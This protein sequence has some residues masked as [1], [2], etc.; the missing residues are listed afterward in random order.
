MLPYVLGIDLNRSESGRR[1][2]PLALPTQPSINN[3]VYGLI[4]FSRSARIPGL[5]GGRNNSTACTETNFLQIVGVCGGVSHLRLCGGTAVSSAKRGFWRASGT[6][7]RELPGVS[8]TESEFPI[9]RPGTY[10]KTLAAWRANRSDR[11]GCTL[12][13]MLAPVLS[14]HGVLTLARALEA[15]AAP[16]LELARGVRLEQAFARGSGHGL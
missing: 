5:C 10:R 9:R 2:S 11:K 6:R 14:P 16:A 1:R 13:V 3:T 4:G 8:C 12:M 7:K 15:D